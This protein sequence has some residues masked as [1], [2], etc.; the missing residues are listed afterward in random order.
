MTVFY[1]TEWDF[2]VGQGLNL[3][4][5]IHRDVWDRH[6][7]GIHAFSCRYTHSDLTSSDDSSF[8]VI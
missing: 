8:P 6:D 5:D 7:A 2:E 1:K 4:F 3:K